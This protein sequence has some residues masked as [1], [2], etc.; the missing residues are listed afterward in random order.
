MSTDI[1]KLFEDGENLADQSRFLPAVETFKE[2]QRLTEIPWRRA[3]ATYNL[4]TIY[5]HHLGNGL[6]ARHEFL[7]AIGD[8]EQFGH[9]D[10]PIFKTVHANALENAML[11]A[12]SYDE[13]EELAGKL[14]AISPGIPILTGLVPDVNNHRDRGK[15]WSDSLFGLAG[16]YYNRSDPK[17]DAGRYGEAKSTYHLMLANRKQLRLSEENWR[18]AIYE[19]CALSM[20]MTSDCLKVR[21]GDDDQNSPEE[22]LPILTEA[23]PLVDEYL[24]LNSGDDI[25]QKVRADMEM[26]VIDIRRHWDAMNARQNS[27]PGKTFYRVCQQCGTVYAQMQMSG[28]ELMMFPFD[29]SMCMK[30]GGRVEWQ[31][32]PAITRMT[33]RGCFPTFSFLFFLMGTIFFLLKINQIINI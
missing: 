3:W 12:L 29:S 10:T 23:I 19:F 15:P 27:V 32:S 25:V 1:E 33:G 11:C 6:E 9:G 16:S 26:M 31:E 5:W 22:Y 13:F 8:F 18:I 4:A 28:P 21:G 17:L 24:S 7:A 2:A 30:C 14:N 20:R